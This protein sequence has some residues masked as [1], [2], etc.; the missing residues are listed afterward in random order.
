[1]KPDSE[2]TLKEI[3]K[4]LKQDQKKVFIVGHTDTQGGY[5]YNKNL[6]ARRAKAVAEVLSKQYGI[7]A[8]R[9]QSAGVGYLAPVASNDSEEGRAKNR[10]VELVQE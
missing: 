3:A 6:S 4:L 5:E 8:S 2:P 10:R 1:V 7:P 9:L